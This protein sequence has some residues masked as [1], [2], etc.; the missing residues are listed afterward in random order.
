MT[1]TTWCVSFLSG[2]GGVHLPDSISGRTFVSCWWLFCIIIVG[3][4]CGNLI[5]FLTVTKD[6]APFGTLEEMVDMK[7]E[8]KWGVQAGTNW[9]VV[10]TVSVVYMSSILKNMAKFC[11]C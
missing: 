4:Y 3:T 9:E 7:N 11:L 6:R 5:A 1:S 8:Y 10:F 2:I